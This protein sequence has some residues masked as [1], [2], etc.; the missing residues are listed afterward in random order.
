[1]EGTHS[2]INRRHPRVDWRLE[3]ET[4]SF[5][6]TRFRYSNHTQSKCTL[7]NQW[8]NKN[9]SQNTHWNSIY[10][11][12]RFTREFICLVNCYELAK[13][14]KC[15]FF[16]NCR[17]SVIQ[18]HIICCAICACLTSNVIKPTWSIMIFQT[19]TYLQ[20]DTNCFNSIYYRVG[21]VKR[22]KQFFRSN[23]E[24]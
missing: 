10:I 24:I 19:G 20:N 14:D 15:F 22:R 9:S 8:R 6:S 7:S 12:I 1:M 18:C 5:E 3:Q 23:E 17:C 13:K 2:F 16:R 11:H 4:F 21:F